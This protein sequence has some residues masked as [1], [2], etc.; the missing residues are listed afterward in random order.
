MLAA[1]NRMAKRGAHTLRHAG[2]MP[3][4]SVYN[5]RCGYSNNSRGGGAAGAGGGHGPAAQGKGQGWRLQRLRRMLSGR[6]LRPGGWPRPQ[7]LSA[8]PRYSKPL[9][10]FGLAE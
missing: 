6:Q 5:E 7:G 4:R 10:N 1:G 3:E 8:A 2:R 9:E